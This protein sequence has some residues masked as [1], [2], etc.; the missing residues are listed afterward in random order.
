MYVHTDDTD[1]KAPH[2]ELARS[3]ARRRSLENREDTAAALDGQRNRADL[4]DAPNR[5]AVPPRLLTHVLRI[6]LAAFTEW[7]NVS[8]AERAATNGG[9]DG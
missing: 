8:T 1:P 2:C 9:G 3:L 5:D 6:C 7:G 4:Q